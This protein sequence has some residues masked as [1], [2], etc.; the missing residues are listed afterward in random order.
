MAA[1]ASR[2]L[3]CGAGSV[4]SGTTPRL[5]APVA[6]HAGLPHERVAEIQRSRLLAATVQ[7]LDQLGYE[8]TTVAHITRR[9]GVSRRTFYDLFANREECVAAVVRHAAQLVGRELADVGIAS[10]GWRERMR[11]GLWTILAFLERE[12]RLARVLVVH[13]LRGSGPVLRAREE[14]IDQL[15]AAVDAGRR[16]GSRP[17]GCSPLTAEGVVGAALAILQ[18]RLT[19]KEYEPL[20][21]LLGELAAIVVLP[22]LGAAI[23][24]R[25]QTKPA[26]A[27]PKA[28]GAQP[29]PGSAPD[30]LTGL[31]MRIT[32]R[33]TLV[34]EG[35][36]RR[37]GASNRQVADYAGITDQGQI[38]KLLARLERL[39]L[40]VN[41]GAGRAKGEPNAW[42]LT[43][44]GALVARSIA[45]HRGV[46][47]ERRRAA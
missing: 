14:I 12:P 35:I 36:G 27:P 24:R 47:A 42:T 45:S 32:Y 39:G 44:T 19:R 15:T 18:A 38:S 23:A 31:P 11:G 34:L 16:E 8:R 9:A 29:A 46:S 28:A 6:A 2:A 40:L 13:T 22:Y 26:P 30:P 43:A 3:R 20:T 7:V 41:E 21:A 33:T 10:L 1:H 25:E 37:R 5:S 4:T 17:N